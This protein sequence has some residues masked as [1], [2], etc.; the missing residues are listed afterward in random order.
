MI[1]VVVCTDAWKL[2]AMLARSLLPAVQKMR[3]FVVTPLS[4][5][6]RFMGSSS[7]PERVAIV[8]SGNWCVV[9]VARCLRA[10]PA[11]CR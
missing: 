3:R 8:G 2:T 5:G 10:R 11:A 9:R 6:L 4:H 1:V 7:A